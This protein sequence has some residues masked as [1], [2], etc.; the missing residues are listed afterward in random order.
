MLDEV[1]RLA[2]LGVRV[3]PC[4]S[5]PGGCC[6]C[7]Q[8]PCGT[9]NKNAGKHPCT[10]HGLKDATTNEQQIHAW[11]TEYPGCNWAVATGLGFGVLDVDGGK[12]RASL[13]VLEARHGKL[14]ETLT[15]LTGREDGG[16]HRYF[17]CPPGHEIRNTA[18]RLGEGLDTRGAGGY[19]LVPC[20]VHRTGRTYEWENPDA[21][22][23][24]APA[25]LLDLI[26]GPTPAMGRVPVRQIGILTEGRRNDGLF[27]YGCALRRKGAE[28]ADIEAN[29]LEANTRRCYPPLAYQEVQKISASAS[30]YP[31]GGPDPLELAWEASRKQ[32]YVSPY[33]QFLGLCR[34]LQL[35]RPQLTI[36]LPLKRIGKLMDCD[37]TQV[38]RWRSRAVRQGRLRPME[39]YIAH[40]R[41]AHYSYIEC[42]TRDNVTKKNSSRDVPLGA[43]SPSVECPTK[44]LVRQVSGTLGPSGTVTDS[45]A[46]GYVEGWL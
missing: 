36:A 6:S 43:C 31:V 33:E 38:R 1:L 19:V 34:H 17:A 5:A 15:C 18:G 45:S 23:A 22:I 39:K 28:Q 9:E 2:A 13:A 37:W 12:G 29:L 16:E 21:R 14:P 35:A 4:H 46:S 26:T 11:A 30:K 20:S 32:I 10:R 7:G 41:A 3:L 8:Y 25:W 24:S 27:R 44:P 42:T 40:R